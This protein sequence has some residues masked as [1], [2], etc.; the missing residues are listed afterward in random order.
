[1]SQTTKCSLKVGNLVNS[2]KDFLEYDAVVNLFRILRLNTFRLLLFRYIIV[3]A[4]VERGVD[5]GLDVRADPSVDG[6]GF[7]VY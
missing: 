4:R 5:A 7:I 3:I 6:R 1:M 2:R